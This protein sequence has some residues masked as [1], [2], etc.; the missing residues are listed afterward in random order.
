M[1]SGITFKVKEVGKNQSLERNREEGRDREAKKGKA[2]GEEREARFTG[3]VRGGDSL[4]SS[5]DAKKEEGKEYAYAFNG[6]SG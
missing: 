6:F 2:Y 5:L 4:C 3:G 1:R